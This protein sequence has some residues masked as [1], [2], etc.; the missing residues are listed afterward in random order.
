MVPARV[1]SSTLLGVDAH[2]DEVEVDLSMGLPLFTTVRL[3]DA[4]L[5]KSRDRVKA[6][7]GPESTSVSL[8]FCGSSRWEI[9]VPVE[10]GA[11]PGK[12]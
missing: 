12:R 3:P 11:G 9:P 7:A 6:V 5:R 4:A 10:S 8:T 1:L 2:P